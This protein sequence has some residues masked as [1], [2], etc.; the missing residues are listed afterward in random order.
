M[1]STA[2]WKGLM[3]PYCADGDN[4]NKAGLA[5]TE[6]NWHCIYFWQNR[7]DSNSNHLQR[8]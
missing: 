8:Y 1:E 2:L 6:L 3:P 7:L 4:V 5:K